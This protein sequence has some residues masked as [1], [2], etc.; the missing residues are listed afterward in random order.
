MPEPPQRQQARRVDLGAT[1]GGG[2]GCK[3]GYDVE[4]ACFCFH[5]LILVSVVLLD[6]VKQVAT[7]EE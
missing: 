6:P 7:G 2:A 3:V 5:G 4:D 1:C